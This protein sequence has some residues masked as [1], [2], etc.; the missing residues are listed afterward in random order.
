MAARYLS[1]STSGYSAPL[2]LLVM[3]LSLST[4]TATL[5]QTLD[6]HMHDQTFYKVGA[7]VHVIELGELQ[8]GASSGLGGS[9]QAGQAGQARY[10]RG[11]ADQAGKLGLPAGL[12]APQ[13]AG[14]ARPPRA[15]RAS[16]RA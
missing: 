9:A 8:G 7:D 5:A 1:R 6:R 3:T 4:F 12:R 2:I 10:R 16:R 14:R 11:R 15:W 13:G